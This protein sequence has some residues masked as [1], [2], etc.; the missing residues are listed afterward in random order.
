MHRKGTQPQRS[1]TTSDATISAC[2]G[3]ATI[4]TSS[5]GDATIRASSVADATSYDGAATINSASIIAAAATTILVVRIAVAVI[6]ATAIVTPTYN[7]PPSND[8][9]TSIHCGS[10]IASVGDAA[11]TITAC[12]VGDAASTITACSVGDTTPTEA[13]ASATATPVRESLIGNGYRT[14]DE[15]SSNG[16]DGSV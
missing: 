1:A 12:S 6:V 4:R 16:N 10:A 5:V 15:C 2:S 9:S 13:T 7:C 8:R 3:D 11:S 14:Q